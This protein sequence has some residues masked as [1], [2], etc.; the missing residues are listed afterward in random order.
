MKTPFVYF[1]IAFLLNVQAVAED[2]LEINVGPPRSETS[3][4]SVTL[5]RHEIESSKPTI[6]DALRDIPGLFV[7][8]SGGVGQPAFL[9]IRGNPSQAT[10]VLLDGMPLND[11]SLSTSIFDFSDANFNNLDYVRVQKGVQTVRYGPGATGGVV[12]LRSRPGHG[13]PEAALKAGVGSLFSSQESVGVSQ[14]N[15]NWGY[16]GEISNN[17]T[18]GQSVAPSQV[19]RDGN[20]AEA[21][22]VRLDRKGERS[23]ERLIIRAQQRMTDLDYALQDAPP[24]IET[25]AK[26]YFTRSNMVA[27]GSGWD[28]SWDAHWSSSGFLSVV[29]QQ[30]WFI[31]NPSES[32]PSWSRAEYKG[33]KTTGD[34]HFEWQNAHHKLTFGPQV[35]IDHATSHSMIKNKAAPVIRTHSSLVGLNTI[36]NL[37]QDWFF[38]EAGA[39]VDEHSQF[40]EA[41]SFSLLIGIRPTEKSTVEFKIAQG[42]NAPSLSQL[43]DPIYGNPLLKPENIINYDLSTQIYLIANLNLIISVFENM[44]T[45]LIQFRGNTYDN[46]AEAKITGIEGQLAWKD[47][48]IDTAVGFTLL[49]AVND[50]DGSRLLRRPLVT[51]TARS[52]I[53]LGPKL[54]IGA[55]YM[56]V[57]NRP[58]VDPIAGQSTNVSAYHLVNNQVRFLPSRDLELTFLVSNT[59]DTQ[60]S[61]NAGYSGSER[62]FWLKGTYRF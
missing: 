24:F 17:Q 38:S 34:F 6:E 26:A 31:N 21:A 35:Y 11:P 60:F 42:Q 23:S 54:F 52:M 61:E 25:D 58:D 22:S 16:S 56:F 51:A 18:L 41:Y 10:L 37:T 33:Q 13:P 62:E 59:L 40:S 3:N 48:L 44:M 53:R 12:E 29:S 55:D 7:S 49:D 32:N 39:R 14:G 2:L 30:R 9:F 50:S 20:Q 27:V 1:V 19:E 4:S 36:W 45:D 43:Y 8:R 15:A 47:T 5:S 46:V 57:S 28:Q